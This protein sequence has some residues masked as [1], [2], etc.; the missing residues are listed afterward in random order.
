MATGPLNP[1]AWT[2]E[3]VNDGG[4]SPTQAVRSGDL[5]IFGVMWQD[6]TLTMVATKDKR[7]AIP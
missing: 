3:F 2:Q 7:I 5:P 4:I 6:H 1:N